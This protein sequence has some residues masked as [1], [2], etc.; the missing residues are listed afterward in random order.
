MENAI[1][2]RQSKAKIWIENLWHYAEEKN[3][4][5]RILDEVEECRERL[6]S[7]EIDWDAMDTTVGELLE[8]IEEKEYPVTTKKEQFK[9]EISAAD[10]EAQVK[11]MA[12]RCH[13]DNITSLESMEEQ[14]NIVI[15]KNCEQ[16]MEISY[17]KAH[18]EELKNEDLY[19]QFFQNRKMVYEKD[20]SEMIRDMLQS[21]SGNYNHMLNHMRSMFQSIGG[22][23]NGMGNEKFY[24]EYEERRTGIDAKVRGEAESADI[25]GEDIISFGQK[26]GQTIKN[27]VNKLVWKRKILAWLPLIILLCIFAGNAIIKQEQSKAVVESSANADEDNAE[28]R[29]EVLKIGVKALEKVTSKLIKSV[30]NFVLSLLLS[31]GAVLIFIILLV[32]VI[33]V[34]YLK[35]LK[36]WCDQQICKSCGEFLK[37]ELSQFTQNNIFSS[38]L[39]AVMENAV[40]VYE[41][42][43]MIVLSNLFQDSPYGSDHEQ[44]SNR[45]KISLLRDEWKKIMYE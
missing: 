44:E 36:A 12:Q 13:A 9:Q 7:V 19:L 43:Y 22:Y 3:M 26:T 21:I 45:S 20:V 34:F 41:Q 18:L 11:K 16:I 10:V 4:P 27:I 40:N 1:N 5:M 28:I 23:K 42:Q 6:S 14:K 17:T 37:T 35:A 32:I 39:D 25:G 24:Q 8:S 29:E 2:E 31:I 30:I 38:K 33:Y 15:K